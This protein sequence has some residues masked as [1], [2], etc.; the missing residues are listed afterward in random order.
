MRIEQVMAFTPIF[1][2]IRVLVRLTSKG[3]GFYA[4]IR[5][6]IH[7]KPIRIWNFR[8]MYVNTDNEIIQKILKK[9]EWSS[10]RKIKYDP[11]ITYI[12]K[13]LRRFTL[14]EFPQLFNVCNDSMSIIGPRPIVREEAALYGKYSRLIHSVRPG[15]TSLWQVSGRNTVT[16]HRRIAINIYYDYVK[17]KSWKLDLGILHKTVWAVIGGR[18]A[19]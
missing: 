3:A 18:G 13:I 6:G 15:I 16:Y 4:S 2:L 17:H 19:Y 5:L 7:S 8:S 14:D 12:G 10:F 9:E 1:A 11:R